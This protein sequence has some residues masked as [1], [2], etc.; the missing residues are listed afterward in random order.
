M[1]D[2]PQAKKHTITFI[3]YSPDQP[4]VSSTVSADSISLIG[5]T[6]NYDRNGNQCISI[7]LKSGAVLE[8]PVRPTID[9]LQQIYADINKAYSGDRNAK[10]EFHLVLKP[11]YD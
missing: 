2:A 6:A 4:P 11:H 3:V 5:A 10:F 7:T 1:K 9:D 8:Y